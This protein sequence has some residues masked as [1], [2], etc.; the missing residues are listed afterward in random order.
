MLYMITN[1]PRHLHR[2]PLRCYP[3]HYRSIAQ[4]HNRHPWTHHRSLSQL[5]HHEISNLCCKSRGICIPASCS[6]SSS[7]SSASSSTGTEISFSRTRACLSFGFLSFIPAMIA[8][9]FWLARSRCLRTSLP[10]SP[11]SAGQSSFGKSSLSAK[12]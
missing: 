12:H 2:P 4:R 9:F 3:P 8:D 10:A 11:S 5:L 6:R 7:T 1:N